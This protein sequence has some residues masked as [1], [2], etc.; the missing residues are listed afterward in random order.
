MTNKTVLET[1]NNE[2]GFWGT[3]LINYTPEETA[4]RWEEAFETLL[5]LSG[6][7]AESIREYLDDRSGRHL[8]DTCYG[9]EVKDTIL[10][11]YYNWCEKDLFGDKHK[12]IK[13]KDRTMFGT[14]VLNHITGNK[15]VLLYTYK[16]PDRVYKEYATCIDINEKVYDIGMAYISPIEE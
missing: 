2:Y 14:L 9:K 4:K 5:L 3:T 1:Q 6:K 7:D 12:L 10:K 8:A 13:L 11:N 15:D 16:N